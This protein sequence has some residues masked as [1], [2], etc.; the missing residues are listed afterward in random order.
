MVVCPNMLLFAAIDIVARW[1][2]HNGLEFKTSRVMK[3]D[4]IIRVYHM[5][6]DPLYVVSPLEQAR[7]NRVREMKAARTRTKRNNEDAEAKERNKKEAK[8]RM[9]QV[10]RN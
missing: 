4:N 1:A 9:A 8:E 5:A 6:T 10:R 2:S 7:I 3:L